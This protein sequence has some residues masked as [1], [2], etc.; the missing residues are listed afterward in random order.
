MEE[1]GKFADLYDRMMEEIPY[2]EWCACLI[3]QLE[4]FGIRDGLVLELGCGT[5]T[6]CERLAEAGYDMTGIDVSTDMLNVAE[7]KRRESGLPILYLCQDMREFELYGTMRAVVSVC[8]TMNYLTDRAD[9]V[10]TLKLVNN[11]LDPDGVFIF[12]LKT[13]YFYRDVLGTRTMGSAEDDAAYIWENTF[14]EESGINEYRMTFFEEQEDGRYDR[15]E[16]LHIQRAWI[17]EEL[18]SMAEEAGMRFITCVK[19][20][21]DE[22]PDHKTERIQVILQ[23]QGKTEGREERK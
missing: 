2:D 17:E 1:Y 21:S 23:E 12:D 6:V 22:A 13:L 16:E 10:T 5:G 11:Y 3:R 15:F 14:D 9:F 18:R 7:E 19:A 8:D 4:R 20:Y